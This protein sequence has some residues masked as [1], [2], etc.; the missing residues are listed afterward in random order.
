MSITVKFLKNHG[1]VVTR[2]P[3][4]GKATK[5]FVRPDGALKVS[6]AVA[7]LKTNDMRLYRLARAGKLRVVRI[8]GEKQ[9]PLSE[10][11]RLMG[12]RTALWPSL[13]KGVA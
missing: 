2:R 10:V 3:A 7:V 13:K 6:E 9:F 12:D 11:K 8:S 5:R 1:A 4:F